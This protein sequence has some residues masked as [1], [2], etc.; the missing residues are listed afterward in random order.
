MFWRNRLGN[1][2]VRQIKNKKRIITRFVLMSG[3]PQNLHKSE[4][5]NIWKWIFFSIA[6]SCC[7][8]FT[9]STEKAV[10]WLHMQV[11]TVSFREVLQPSFFQLK[12]EEIQ[13]KTLISHVKYTQE[14]NSIGY[15]SW[16]PKALK[17][18]PLLQIPQARQKHIPI[19]RWETHKDR[20]IFTGLYCYYSQSGH[21]YPP[22]S[23]I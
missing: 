8:V 17:Q 12:P 5:V 22:S 9:K 1:L 7:N 2:L 15:W 18:N 20:N 6:T 4:R 14:I 3:S 21:R 10:V 23:S 11:T 19:A 16:E 13:R